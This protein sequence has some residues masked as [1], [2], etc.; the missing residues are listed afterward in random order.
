MDQQGGPNRADARAGS[1]V[2]VPDTVAKGD[3]VQV[4]GRWHRVRRVNKT[5][6]T[7]P[8]YFWAAPQPGEREYTY[9]TPWGGV[10]EHR[11]TD[12]MPAGF[13]E[14]YE[15]PGAERLHLKVSEFESPG[16]DCSS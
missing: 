10:R 3:W 9:P 7:V 4:R 1:V 16:P 15:T 12:A 13:V 14:A 6:V 2:A 8:C 11:K 5:S